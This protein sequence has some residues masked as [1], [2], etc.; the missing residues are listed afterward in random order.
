M[1]TIHFL[2]ICKTMNKFLDDICPSISI[3]ILSR[4]FSR[5][6]GRLEQIIDFYMAPWDLYLKIVGDVQ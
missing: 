5:L 4:N 1:I 6:C 3:L 2:T